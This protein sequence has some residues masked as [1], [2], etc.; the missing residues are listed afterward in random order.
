MN[1]ERTGGRFRVTSS[2]HRF[3]QQQGWQRRPGRACLG[4]GQW[5]PGDT[6]QDAGQ[7]HGG[8]GGRD[9]MGSTGHHTVFWRTWCCLP[10]KAG[11]HG[12]SPFLSSQ[13]ISMGIYA[14]HTATKRTHKR[15]HSV[16]V[17]IYFPHLMSWH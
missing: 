7:G 9:N 4:L 14:D 17:K 2:E 10:D 12:T 5:A 16:W 11:K 15:A 3:Q 13:A 8:D 1:C 6:D